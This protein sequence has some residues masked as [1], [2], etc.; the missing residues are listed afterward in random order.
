MGGS[1]QPVIQEIE[2]LMQ[3]IINK[4]SNE[5][6]QIKPNE[7]FRNKDS[8]VWSWVSSYSAIAKVY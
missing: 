2:I 8:W 6:Q 3:Y 7:M 1:Y 4:M 5:E